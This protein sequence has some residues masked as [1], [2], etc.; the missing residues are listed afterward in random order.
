MA[1]LQ[2]VDKPN[3]SALIIRRT[4]KQLSKA[5]ALMD[6]A[7]QWLRNT[8]ANW[9]DEE[10]K[11]TFPSGATLEF[12]YLDSVKDRDNFMSAAYNYIAFDELTQFRE[13]DYRFLFSRLRKTED[14]PIPSRMRSASNPGSIGHAWTKK[15]FNT[16]HPADPK[17]DL[18]P[19]ERLFIPATL[20]D[21]PSLNK[22]DYLDSL[23]M[24]P[25]RE[26]RQMECG[27]W[28]DY[29]GAWWRPNQ[30]PRWIDLG[31]AVSIPGAPH[32][33]IYLWRD[34]P[35]FVGIDWATSEKKTANWTSF[36]C[37]GLTPCHKL[38]IRGMFVDQINLEDNPEYLAQF[39][40]IW[41]PVGVCGEDD[42]LSK[43]MVLACRRLPDIPEIQMIPIG[44]KS[45]LVR[46]TSGIVQAENQRVLLPALKDG[47]IDSP[48]WLERF[49]DQLQA[50]TGN[51]DPEDD[52][53]DAFGVLCRK[54][55][56]MRGIDTSG[57]DDFPEVFHPGKD[58]W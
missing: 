42:T 35:N 55:D 6:I 29:T 32:R 13:E 36:V 50:V 27:D 12:G 3:Y 33:Q 44:S 22:K 51:D 14:S 34:I 49:K 38:L 54:I 17:D 11:W 19:M 18:K 43:T 10:H 7:R 23:A 31:D 45:K 26:R 4:Y 39:C 41:R 48:E 1:A 2:F 37:G 46:W 8:A 21:N 15:R 28:S 56:G 20:D 53:A 47:E 24:L 9:K 58:V 57:D 16:E 5:G 40:R 52:I 30:W 25:M